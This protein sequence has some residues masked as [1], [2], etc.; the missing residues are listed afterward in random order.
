MLKRIVGAAA[1]AGML[2]GL[3][4]TALQQLAVAPLIRDAEI[5]EAAA[6][7]APASALAAATADHAHTAWS[8][9]DGG[10]RLLAAGFANIV[11]A[12]GFALLLA[13]AQ[14]LRG[15]TG[16]RA[17]LWWGAAGYAVFFVAPALG[18]PPELPGAVAAPLR[19]SQLWWLGSCSPLRPGL[20]SSCSARNHCSA[21]WVSP[22]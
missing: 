16:W 17:G 8:P 12:T 10:E 15:A 5:R 9:R 7:V 2:S 1:L 20:R 18:L 21:C 4:L 19:E 11:L 13:A 6:V 14:G 3:L 22:C